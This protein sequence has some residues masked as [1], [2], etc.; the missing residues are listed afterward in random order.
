MVSNRGVSAEDGRVGV[1]HHMVFNSGVS[2]NIP[3]ILPAFILGET[4]RAE[5]DTLI[6]LDVIPHD[7]GLANDDSGSMIDKQ[8][9]AER[10]LRMDVDPVK[11]VRPLGNHPGQKVGAGIPNFM[12]Q[13]VDHEGMEARIADHDLVGALASRISVDGGLDIGSQ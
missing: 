10:C 2:F 12:G 4:E 13:P 1:D 7:A 6:N 11:A 5:G 8:V 3:K 9:A